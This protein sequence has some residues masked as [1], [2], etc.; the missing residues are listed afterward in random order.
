MRKIGI[1]YGRGKIG[2][3]AGHGASCRLRSSRSLKREQGIAVKMVVRQFGQSGADGP[4]VW[5]SDHTF[6]VSLCRGSEQKRR[7]VLRKAG[8]S[9]REDDFCH[10]HE[11]SFHYG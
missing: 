2:Y 10:E 7:F 6:R 8:S 3:L 9:R 4:V 1:F 11:N 5:L